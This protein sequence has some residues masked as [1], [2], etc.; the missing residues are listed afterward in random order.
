MHII[1]TA[2]RGT[3]VRTRNGWRGGVAV[4]VSAAA[5]SGVVDEEVAVVEALVPSAGRAAES[6]TG[7]PSFETGALALNLLNGL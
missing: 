1:M 7:E 2:G 4:V 3:D 6:L 5:L